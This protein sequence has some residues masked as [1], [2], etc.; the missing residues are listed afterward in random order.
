VSL[1]ERAATREWTDS[2]IAS[3][4]FT[5]LRPR[6]AA[7]P[8]KPDKP[9]D[10]L[11]CLGG[12]V[13]VNRVIQEKVQEKGTFTISQIGN[14]NVP[15][16]PETGLEPALPVKATR[17]STWRVCQFRH[18]GSCFNRAGGRLAK[19]CQTTFNHSGDEIIN[20]NGR[21]SRASRYESAPAMSIGP[22]QYA[23]PKGWCFR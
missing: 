11:C 15:L 12:R 19:N 17:P 4:R 16:V 9:N 14:V 10:N 5:Q 8:D 1:P 6:G 21:F 22:K 13:G 2:I 23:R 3:P 20:V 18:S 7:A